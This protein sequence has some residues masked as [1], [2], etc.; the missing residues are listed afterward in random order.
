MYIG[1]I[2]RDNPRSEATA[3]YTN[4]GS[5]RILLLGGTLF[6]IVNMCVRKRTC[7]NH[8]FLGGSD[9]P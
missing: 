8:A 9:P 2:A 4:Q 7:A 6:G 5:Y 3:V 1:R